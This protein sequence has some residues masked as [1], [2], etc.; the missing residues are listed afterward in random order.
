MY[1]LP[2]LKGLGTSAWCLSL[3]TLHLPRGVIQTFQD[4]EA[5]NHDERPLFFFL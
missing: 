5:V 4:T 1:A 3:L 2:S